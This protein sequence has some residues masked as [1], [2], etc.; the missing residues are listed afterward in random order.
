L[1]NLKEAIN[2]LIQHLNS[3]H[4]YRESWKANI[5]MAFLDEFGSY[6]HHETANRAAERFLDLLCREIP[7][8][9]NYNRKGVEL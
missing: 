3:D 8:E 5:A 9:I 4:A 2:V 7:E 6:Q 1:I